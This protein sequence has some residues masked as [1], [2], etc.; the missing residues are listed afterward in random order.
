[1]TAVLV[2][3]DQDPDTEEDHVERH[4]EKVAEE[5]REELRRAALEETNTSHLDLGRA[6]SRI[7]RK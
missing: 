2:R 3:R 7:V 6:A 5:S 4:R 1:M